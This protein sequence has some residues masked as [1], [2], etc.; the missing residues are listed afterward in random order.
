MLEFSEVLPQRSGMRKQK[1][2]V[3]QFVSVM[4]CGIAVVAALTGFL[5]YFPISGIG[6]SLLY[7]YALELDE[8]KSMS[9]WR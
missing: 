7:C 5:W 8:T 6:I 2:L 1:L 9:L 3:T 4:N